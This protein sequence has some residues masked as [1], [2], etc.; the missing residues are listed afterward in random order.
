MMKQSKNKPDIF[1]FSQLDF[2]EPRFPFLSETINV[3]AIPITNYDNWFTKQI[4][5]KARNMVRKAHK[6]GV[7]VR[8]VAFDDKLFEGIVKIYNETPVRQGKTFWHYNKDVK[9]I[10]DGIL[11]Y[12][13]RCDF[14]GAYANGELLGFAKVVYMADMARIM[15][16]ISMIKD[17]DKAPN[18]A[19]IAKAVEICAEKGARYLIYG[20]YD[21][22]KENHNS[23]LNFK[24]QNGF[25][26]IENTKYYVPIT[27]KGRYAIQFGFHVGIIKMMPDWLRSTLTILRTKLIEH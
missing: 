11:S 20:D 9:L 3:A 23:L 21:Y 14:I 19:L 12:I 6:N 17:R 13:T 26:K 4:N 24:K 16:I 15:Q 7:D 27:M 5:A 2:K 8:L 1:T 18:N 22:G 10:H 25:Q